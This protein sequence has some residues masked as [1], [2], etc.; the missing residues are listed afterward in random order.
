LALALASCGSQSEKTLHVVTV[1]DP[2]ELFAPDVAAADSPA[3]M[4]RSATSEGLVGFDEEGRVIPALADRWIVLDEGQS[5][6][7]RLREGSWA[8][9]RPLTAQS[10]QVALHDAIEGLKGRA[11]ALDLA[12]VEDIRVMAAR[13]IEIRLRQPTP[14]LLQ[15]LAQPELGLA[16]HGSTAGP[17]ALKREGASAVLT[18]IRPEK[19]GLPAIKSWG[20]RIRTVQLTAEDSQIAVD[21]FGRGDADLMLG[22]TAIQFPLAASLGVGRGAIRMDAVSGLFGLAVVKEAGILA[23]PASREALSMAIDRDALVG[24]FGVTG[25]A[26]TT[27]IVPADAT[28]GLAPRSERWSGMRM[29]DRRSKARAVVERWRIQSGEGSGPTLGVALPAGPGSDAIFARLAADFAAIGVSL[30]RAGK[31]SEAD[32]RLVDK[33]ARYSAPSWY[34]NQFNCMLNRGACDRETDALMDQVRAT[35]DPGTRDRLLEEAEAS[36]T[37]ANVF[38]PLAEPMRWSLVRGDAPGFS[39]N[40]LGY[41]PLMPLA[42]LPR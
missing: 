23:D 22:G 2:A 38:I 28:E 24:A 13:V 39:I 16:Y 31:P 35:Q 33:V 41:H 18:L 19:L 7:F 21:Q 37:H 20:S 8:D 14:D 42:L 11:L 15:L 4:V 9:G 3:R 34:L 26:T 1:G 40:R 30:Q 29:D 32:L 10:A 5:Y 6:I 25:W 17:M 27:R 36:L 12:T